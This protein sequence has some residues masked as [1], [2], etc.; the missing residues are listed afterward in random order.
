MIRILTPVEKT[1]VRCACGAV[2]SV[3][4]HE[5]R[6]GTYGGELAVKCP[7]CQKEVTKPGTEYQGDF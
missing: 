7:N 3:K 4:S 6:D 5:W 2:L 1:I